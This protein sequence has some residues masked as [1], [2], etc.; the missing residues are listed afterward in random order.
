MTA[1]RDILHGTGA[2]RLK[3]ATRALVETVGGTDGAART[4]S[5][6]DRRVRQQRV[7]DCQC[8]NTADF[9][10]LDEV[11]LL[12]DVAIHMP[13]W[14]PVTRALADRHGFELVRRPDVAA[15][16]VDL[17]AL[18]GRLAKEHGELASGVC[19]DLACDRRT[20]AEEARERLADA[21][22]LVRVA[23]EMEAVLRTI[24]DSGADTG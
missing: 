6:P 23:L 8:R 5:T 12:E 22:D 16:G 2:L 3:A 10:R 21:R 11:A 7:S 14:P 13:A 20:P 9:L 17:T 15:S 18:I 1:R 19:A 4:L 24:A